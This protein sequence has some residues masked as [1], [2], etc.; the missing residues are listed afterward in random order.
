MLPLIDGK[1]DFVF[2]HCYFGGWP[3]D[4]AG[5]YI[6]AT[7]DT[8]WN[9]LHQVSDTAGNTLDM[10]TRY[11]RVSPIPVAFTEFNLVESPPQAIELFNG[12][13]TAEVLGEQLAAGFSA[14]NIWD[15][16]NGLTDKNGGDH[17]LLATSDPA[18]PDATPRPS[19]YTYALF[20]RAFGDTMVTASSSL[21]PTVKVL[22]SRFAGGE[23][24]LVAINRGDAPVSLHIRFPG[25]TPQGPFNAWVLT[26]ASLEALQVSW[27]GEAG[28]AG[29]GGPFPIDTIPPYVGQIDPGDST[30]SLPPRSLS[31]V[32]VY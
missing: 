5:T 24:G 14:S 28:P 25:F 3:Y 9:D 20:S 6:P 7:H 26:G 30:L 11:T 15:W 2:Q 8:F 10:L 16:Q 1:V 4:G 13:Y 12:L 19:Y 31:G 18:V 29:G 32:V 21:A 27:N 17:G 23:I 22:A